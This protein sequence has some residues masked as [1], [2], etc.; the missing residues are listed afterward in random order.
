MAAAGAVFIV[1]VVMV[2]LMVVLVFVVVAAAGAVLVV[3][4]MMVMLVVVL[5][6]FLQLMGQGVGVLNGLL[7]GFAVQLIPGGGDDDGFAIVLVQQGEAGGEL[8]FAESVGAAEDDGRGMGDLVI[9]KFAEILHVH[10][11]LAGVGHGG[12]G[13]DDDAFHTGHSG[14]NVAELAHAGGLDEDAVG[15]ILGQHLAEGIVEITHQRTADAA[16]VHLVDLDAGFLHE[17]AVDADV[18]EFVFDEHQ[19]FT[20][21]G[22]GD[23]LFDEGGFSGAEKP[24]ENISF[25][26]MF[27]FQK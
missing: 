22:F 5:F 16:G 2:M 12:G 9:I 7:N 3:F 8:F 24:G 1:L 11:A 19:F 23:E 14:E 6:Q 18:T 21:V 17:A 10:F 20:G 13:V 26:H 25:C 15:L 4:V 27:H